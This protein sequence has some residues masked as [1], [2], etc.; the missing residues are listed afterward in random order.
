MNKTRR[1]AIETL[2]LELEEIQGRLSAILEEEQES[3]DNLPEGFQNGEK[4]EKIQECVDV[5][6]EQVDNL[7]NICGELQQLL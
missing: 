5:L 7:E 1:K 4:G 2:G 3:F 6:E